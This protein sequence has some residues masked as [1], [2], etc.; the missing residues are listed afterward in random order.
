MFSSFYYPAEASYAWCIVPKKFFI[1][2]KYKIPYFFA[3]IS[4]ILMKYC[5]ALKCIDIYFLGGSCD[6]EKTRQ[7]IS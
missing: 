1:T 2:Q 6:T 4:P 3:I 5:Q 7:T